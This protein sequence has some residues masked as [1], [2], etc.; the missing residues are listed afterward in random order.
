M[1][2]KNIAIAG[3]V[4][5][6]SLAQA[7]YF[8]I[9]S[10][11]TLD[12]PDAATGFDYGTYA[13]GISGDKVVGY[14]YDANHRAQP[15]VYSN[16]AYTTL[17]VL[18]AP[19]AYANAIDGDNIVGYYWAGT[20]YASFLYDGV[21]YTTISPQ[22]V[23][24]QAYGISGSTIV[25]AHWPYGGNPV[26]FIYDGST[27]SILGGLI[28]L[29]VEGSNIVGG[30]DVNGK[31]FDGET[32]VD[33]SPP[34]ASSAWVRDISGDKMVGSYMYTTEMEGSK[35]K[36]FLYDG[37]DYSVLQIDGAL[38]TEVNGISGDKVSGH[39]T[40]ANGKQHGFIGT[41]QAIPEPSSVMMIGLG[42]LLIAGYRRFY[43]RS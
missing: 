27:F 35:T 38:V 17:S 39:Y 22:G 8:T 10:Y 40:D 43:G 2:N 3:L 1:N 32:V 31:F 4:G 37:I 5:L 41:I 19:Y 15:Y 21:G 20:N 6:C 7:A 30:Y 9:G 14:Y 26:G 16:G 12:H 24:A 34:L 28:G 33:I 42:G 23:N 11:A 13:E 36:G 18:G 29:G 25:G